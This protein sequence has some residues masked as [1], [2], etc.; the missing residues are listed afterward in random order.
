MSFAPLYRSKNMDILEK[1]G[2]LVVELKERKSVDELVS[3]LAEAGISN[4]SRV[5]LRGPSSLVYPAEKRIL[6]EVERAGKVEKKPDK[7]NGYAVQ[8]GSAVPAVASLNFLGDAYRLYDLLNRIPEY[9]HLPE[10]L[11]DTIS[12]ELLENAMH[13]DLLLGTV[14]ALAAATLY[15]IGWYANKRAERKLVEYEFSRFEGEIYTEPL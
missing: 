3:A 5:T 4:Y 14:T 13:S 11:P 2:G 15:L 9:T 6:E 8:L 7:A 12:R 1:E 10:G